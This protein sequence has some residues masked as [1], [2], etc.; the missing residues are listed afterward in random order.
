MGNFTKSVHF[1]LEFDGDH[2]TM[3]M[4]RG[5]RDDMLA[6]EPYMMGDKTKDENGKLVMTFADVLKME[7]ICE[8]I[9]SERITNFNGCKDSD[10]NKIE[11]VDI[12]K[13]NYYIN[14]VSLI[15]NKFMEISFLKEDE[16][17]KSVEQF[18][19]QLTLNEDTKTE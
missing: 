16:V 14:L 13:E 11:L 6:L 2:I 4:Q 10:G 12:M 19:E 17:K 9:L 15:M 8:P 1:E 7:A 3:D 18:E 5:S